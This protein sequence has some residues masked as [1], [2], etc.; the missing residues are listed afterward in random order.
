VKEHQ[1]EIER[2]NKLSLEKLETR[3]DSIQNYLAK[4][5]NSPKKR[6]NNVV[7]NQRKLSLILHFIEQKSRIIS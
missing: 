7:M 4:I 1:R 3:R 2:L 6:L 5:Q